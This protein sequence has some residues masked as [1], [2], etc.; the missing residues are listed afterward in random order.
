MPKET[1]PYFDALE[2]EIAYRDGDLPRALPLGRRALSALARDE[3]LLRSRVATWTADAALRLGQARDAE[4]LFHE[5]LHRFPTALRILSVRL[6]ARVVADGRP[7]SRRV[8]ST[9]LRSPRLS[10]TRDLG[11]VVSVT[12]EGKEGKELKLCL[13]G[14]G[15]RR[16]ACAVKDVSAAKTD[17]ERIAWAIDEL[18]AKVFAPKIDLT[19][20]DINSLDGS[21]VRGDADEVLKQVLGK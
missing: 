14:R 9:L 7:L 1:A 2:G 4:S 19:Q 11:F 8:A 17:D 3:V 18:H 16:Y 12:G 13:L 10:T 5:V 20:Q 21:A 6:P 15:G